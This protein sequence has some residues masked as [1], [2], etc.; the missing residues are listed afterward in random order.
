MD[1]LRMK[2]ILDGRK[3]GRTEEKQYT[4]LPLRGANSPR[5]SPVMGSDQTAADKYFNIGSGA[6]DES[7]R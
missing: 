1:E 5:A 3:D 7:P 6:K 2:N 4:S